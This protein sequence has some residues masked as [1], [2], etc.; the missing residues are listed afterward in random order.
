VK[1][2]EKNNM[3]AWTAKSPKAGSKAFGRAK[4]DGDVFV[5]IGGQ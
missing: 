2:L 3:I 4:Y 1:R 5:G